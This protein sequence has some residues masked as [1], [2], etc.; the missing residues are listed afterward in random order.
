MP[1]ENSKPKHAMNNLP[2]GPRGYPFIGV[3]H[4]MWGNPLQFFDDVTQEYGDIVHIDFGSRYALF[5]S[6]PQHIQYV[7]QENNRNYKKSTSIKVVDKVLGK[8]LPLA[9]GELWLRQRRLMQPAFH[10]KRLSGMAA[11]MTDETEAMLKGRLGI[12]G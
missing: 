2:P 8:G 9:E 3:L 12:G 11:T 7:L 5:L 4:K 1:E 6:N 10:H